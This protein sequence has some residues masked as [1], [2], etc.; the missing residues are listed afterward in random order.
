MHF[1]IQHAGMANGRPVAA[2]KLT[3]AR[4]MSVTVLTYG[5]IVQSLI[6]PDRKGQLGD[7]VLGYAGLDA[8]LKGH[9]FFGAIAGRVANR[10]CEGRFSLDGVDYTLECN[11]PTGHHLHGGSKGFDKAVWGYE[12]EERADCTLIHLHHTSPDGDAGYP[13]RVDMVHTIG[14]GEDGA[15]SLDF[16]AVADADTIIN[17]VNHSYYNLS[18]VEGSTVEDHQLA[19][20][21]LHALAECGGGERRRGGG[22]G[23][24]SHGVLHRGMMSGAATGWAGRDRRTERGVAG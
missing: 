22:S 6:V 8:Y 10:I 4:G 15:L 16:R 23:R 21:Q 7:V 19:A 11:E 9:P 24:V 12:L 13:G 3:N 14:L 5:C 18:G 2:I 1:E 20:G 17:P